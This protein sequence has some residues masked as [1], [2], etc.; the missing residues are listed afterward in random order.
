MQSFILQ[1]GSAGRR[2][3]GAEVALVSL[4]PKYKS[5]GHD[6]FDPLGTMVGTWVRTM[7]Y[8]LQNSSVTIDRAKSPYNIV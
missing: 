6:S 7:Q 4:L 8:P 1:Q 2:V 3:F 5:V